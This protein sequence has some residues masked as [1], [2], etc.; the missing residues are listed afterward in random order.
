[1]TP[2]KRKVPV[3]SIFNVSV[4]AVPLMIPLSRFVVPAAELTLSAEDNVIAFVSVKELLKLSV[5]VP[6]ALPTVNA[7]D[8]NPEPFAI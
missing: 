5:F 3:P 1:M 6:A 7:P 4:A 2:L 8:P